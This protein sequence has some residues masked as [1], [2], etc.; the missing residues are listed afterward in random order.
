MK[1]RKHSGR[2]P[3]NGSGV[4]DGTG[5]LRTPGPLYHGK[6]HKPQ[7]KRELPAR[8]AASPPPRG[9]RIVPTPTRVTG[10]E[11]PPPPPTPTSVGAGARTAGRA[12][13]R[14]AGARTEAIAAAHREMRRT[15]PRTD[16][17]A[18]QPLPGDAGHAGRRGVWSGRGPQGTPEGVAEWAGAGHAG[19]YN[20]R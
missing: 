5:P 19:R 13:P 20:A 14:A 4:T 2:G 11:P 16:S 8:P 9:P 6:P 17:A 10:P 7:S 18:S 1:T 15:A 3:P 12:P